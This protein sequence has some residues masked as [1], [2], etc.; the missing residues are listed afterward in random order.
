MCILASVYLPWAEKQREF[1]TFRV[2]FSTHKSAQ[3]KRELLRELPC[4]LW[5][6]DKIR[7]AWKSACKN[8]VCIFCVLKLLEN[9]FEYIL[10][11]K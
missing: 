3:I 5:H 2:F 4:Q 1:I 8:N 9:I 10:F 7:D 11:F 6:C